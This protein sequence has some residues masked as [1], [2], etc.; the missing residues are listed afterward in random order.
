MA[1]MISWRSIR[2]TESTRWCEHICAEALV[3][4]A[5]LADED[6]FHRPLHVV[7][8]TAPADPAIKGECLVMGIEHQFLRLPKINPHE[9]HPAVRQLHVRRLDHQR[10]ALERDRFVAP[11]ELV[12]LARCKTHRHISLCR[13]P[14]PIAAPCFRIGPW[15]TGAHCRARRRSCAHAASRTSAS[16][17]DAHAEA[18]W[19]PPP[20]SR[21]DP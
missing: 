2:P 4:L 3:V 6:R 12:G 9:R 8:D 10:Q 15:R 17:S 13:R 20:G 11:V 21:S 14:P 5:R 7:V 16:S 19:L 18:A 1:S